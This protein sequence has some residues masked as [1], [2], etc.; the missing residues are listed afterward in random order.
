MAEPKHDASD[1]PRLQP[2]GSQTDLTVL[3]VHRAVVL[4]HGFI[5][6]LGAIPLAF[7]VWQSGWV[8]LPVGILIALGGVAAGL[9][10]LYLAAQVGERLRG[11]TRG[12]V[13]VYALA[14]CAALVVLGSTGQA[15]PAVV[16]LWI[17][18]IGVGASLSLVP[19]AAIGL[20]ALLA[21]CALA[22]CLATGRW[23]LVPG[24]PVWLFAWLLSHGLRAIVGAAFYL[25][26][27]LSAQPVL[28]WVES[29]TPSY[30]LPSD[31][32]PK[33]RA[34]ALVLEGLILVAIGAPLAYLLLWYAVWAYV[35]PILWPLCYLLLVDLIVLPLLPALAWV[36]VSVYG[37]V[38]RRG[39]AWVFAVSPVFVLMAI[40]AVLV[41][42]WVNLHAW[43]LRAAQG[44][45]RW[46]IGPVH[47]TK[48][49]LAGAVWAHV[50]AW[51]LVTALN[52]Q[53]GLWL[54]GTE[55]PGQA[56]YERHRD[57]QIGRLLEKSPVV[58]ANRD[59][60]LPGLYERA[61]QAN[62][63]VAFEDYVLLTGEGPDASRADLGDLSFQTRRRLVGLPWYYS[64]AEM[65]LDRV[66]RCV[67]FGGCLLLAAV[68]LIRLPGLN[69]VLRFAW[70]RFVVFLIRVGLPVGLLA[71]CLLGDS[72]MPDL[73]ALNAG[74]A[75]VGLAV[76]GFACWLGWVISRD[77]SATR[78]Y[79]PFMATRLLQKRR[80]AFFAI[81]AV[82]LCVAMVLIVISVMG[83]FLDLVRERSHGLLGDLIMQNG[84]LLGFPGY[85]EFADRIKKL[86]DEDGNPIVVE[87]T[88]VIYTYGV[89]RIDS[90]K[91]TQMIRVMG[92]R[93][94]EIVNVTRFGE[95]LSHEPLYPGTT[96]LARQQQPYWGRNKDKL[97]VLPPKYEAARAKGLATIHD[98]KQLERFVREPYERYPGPFYYVGH[99]RSDVAELYHT[100]RSMVAELQIIGEDAAAGQW[101]GSSLSRSGMDTEDVLRSAS[102][103]GAKSTTSPSGTTAPTAPPSLSD[104]VLEKASEIEDLLK[105]IVP[106]LP[107]WPELKPVKP[108]LEGL[109]EAL[110]DISDKLE[111]RDK[112]ASAA[113]NAFLGKLNVPLDALAM[114]HDRPGF[115]GASLYGVII[116]RDLIA[117]RE[118][119]GEYKRYY[120]R[121]STMTVAVLP[122]TLSGTFARQQ[123]ISLK[124]RYVDDSRTGV[125][126]IDS[127]CVYIDFEMMQK[128]MQMNPLKKADGS[129][130]TPARASQVLIKLAEGQDLLET[131]RLLSKEWAAHC[132]GWM[133]EGLDAM[134]QVE[135]NT[136]EEQQAQ[137]IAAVQKEKI[138][139]LTL[140]AVISAVAIFLVLCIFYMIVTEKTRDIGI[141]KSVGASAG[142]VA[143]VFLAYGAAIGVVGGALGVWLG[144][145]FVH[146]INTIQDWMAR[147]HPGL[148]I[149]SAEVYTF[150]I[151]PDTV[152]PD[153]AAVIFI[154]AVIS[155]V[156]GATFPALRAGR[157]WP[158]EALRYE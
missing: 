100:L 18:Y 157:T 150:D 78:H 92:I 97:P 6:V 131:R 35:P 8:G 3:E 59:A 129:G 83:G 88:P 13:G 52:A 143:G 91:V 121:G 20:Q 153:E 11:L 103:A 45:G 152:K 128:I 135:I 136:W 37:W 33:R 101:Q 149:W 112:S 26:H 66:E 116:G 9:A 60:I 76:L 114:V 95:G 104:R 32:S 54:I 118:A 141:L 96:H 132:R 109:I 46:Q 119:S 5:H 124:L 115:A 19:G 137:F 105:E 58:R 93:L 41:L 15:L 2:T 49:A 51:F 1:A 80:I 155:S 123:P 55:I 113:I 156:L 10:E 148:R 87:A 43:L 134:H 144:T 81:G 14:A 74:L 110:M 42:V 69:A 17:S 84:S 23:T 89:L 30:L 70:L 64:P 90:S 24:S 125:Y 146:N 22:T 27:D 107:D 82:T 36:I 154:V 127:V 73:Y 39:E 25:I 126:E 106:Y 79:A 133:D 68:T 40:P 102:A 130:T 16:S 28:R 12:V 63:M 140:F 151:I 21:F 138:L 65:S 77:V 85:Q 47:P 139:V 56:L 147:I 67:V 158:V 120:P 117:K 50:T 31:A 4:L 48:Q 108:A 34:A 57:T 98:P 61:I 86:R 7:H 75:I 44:I 71:A 99:H 122:L 72:P 38:A 62:D 94:D 145:V 53:S 29:H 111:A 142:G